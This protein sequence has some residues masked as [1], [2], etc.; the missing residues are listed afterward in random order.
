MHKW[1]SFPLSQKQIQEDKDFYYF[2]GYASVFGNLDLVG[3]VVMQGAFKNSLS[4]RV[5]KLCYQHNI[6]EPIGKITNAYEDS[7]GLF[8]EGK[9]PKDDTLVAGR[10]MPQLKVGSIDSMSIGYNTLDEEREGEKNLLKEVDLWEVS[11]VTVPANT[12]ARITE[13]KSVVPFKDLALSDKEL[14]WDSA[15]AIQRI[16]EFTGSVDVPSETYKNAFLWF[17][18]ENSENFGAYKLPIADIVDNKMV[19]VPR[20]I[21]AVAGVLQGARGGIDIP[22]DDILKIKAN[23]EKYYSKMDLK[24]PWQKSIQDLYQEVDTIKDLSNFLK[25]KG[26]TKNET[27]FVINKAKNFTKTLGKPDSKE[28]NLQVELTN[29]LNNTKEMLKTI[30][31]E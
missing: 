31:G 6:K 17:D 19:A 14:G 18:G 11:F 29:L 9:M 22:E 27:E 24:A 10:I 5:P 23:V 15:K 13:L 20:G 3:D 1:L 7:I 2:K 16:R 21:F 4:K 30:K 25:E 28:G 8:V 26:L 12:M